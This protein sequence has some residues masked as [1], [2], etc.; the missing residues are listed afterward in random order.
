M[1][2]INELVNEIYEDNYSHLEIDEAMGGDCD[3]IVHNTL[4][5]I[6]KYW[7]ESEGECDKCAT[8]YDLSS[9]DN[10]CGDCGNCDT[11]CTHEGEAK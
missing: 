2:T 8:S 4:N 5:T 9:R 3:C 10:R 6:V 1:E 7:H 11:C